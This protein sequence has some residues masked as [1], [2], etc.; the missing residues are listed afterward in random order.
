LP[1][2]VSFFST[3]GIHDVYDHSPNTNRLVLKIHIY[4]YR[5]F[6]VVSQ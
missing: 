5:G 6:Y 2:K 3:F 1:R 4:Q